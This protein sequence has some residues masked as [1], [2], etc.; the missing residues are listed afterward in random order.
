MARSW[1]TIRSATPER[2]LSASSSA[3]TSGSPPTL[4]LVA[5]RARSEGALRQERTS[6]ERSSAC[7]RSQCNGVYASMSPTSRRFGATLGARS[8]RLRA[9][10]TGRDGCESAARSAGP[11]SAKRSAVA[12]FATITA[13]GLASRIFRRRKVA[14][15]ASSRASHRR[16]KPP[17]PF[18]ATIPPS[19]R[20]AAAS[21]TVPVS[22]G[23]QRGQA[24]GSA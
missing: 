4:A 17:S 11:I 21:A 23:P 5:T 9:S 2:R 7:R 18:R 22:F 19:R 13:K 3:A 20:T 24:I 8:P 16:W 10:T 1:P 14:T 15:A 12:R 6:G